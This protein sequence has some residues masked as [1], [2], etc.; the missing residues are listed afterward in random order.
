MSAELL[1]FRGRT[2]NGGSDGE[3]PFTPGVRR[4]LQELG[5]EAAAL[6]GDSAAL[7]ALVEKVRRLEHQAPITFAAVCRLVERELGGAR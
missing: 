4:A 5:L 1:P 7:C 2:K 3:P 6:A